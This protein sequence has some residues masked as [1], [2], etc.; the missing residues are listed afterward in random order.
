MLEFGLFDA[1]SHF[2]IGA[3]TVRHLLEALKI[4]PGKYTEEGC[5]SLDLNR[6]GGAEYKER[7]DSK[8]R[9]KVLRGQRKKKENK[10]QQAEGVTYAAGRF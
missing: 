2:N 5:R 7:E 4:C 6:I 3:R 1:I 8:N 10:N 9:R